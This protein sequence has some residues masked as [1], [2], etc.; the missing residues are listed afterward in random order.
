MPGTEAGSIAR[1]ALIFTLALAPAARAAAGDLDLV[2]RANGASGGSGNGSSQLPVTSKD[3]HL[4]A[5]SSSATNLTA[6]TVPAGVRQAYVRDLSA[7]TTTLASAAA[8]AN[9][10][11]V[12]MSDDGRYVVFG[13]RAT[14]LG[15]TAPGT[16]RV[17]V[18]D[19]VANTTTLVLE[20]AVRPAISADGSTIAVCSNANLAGTGATGA[21]LKVY[22]YDVQSH[23]FELVSRAPGTGAAITGD[24]PSLSDD[25]TTIAFSGQGGTA[26]IWVRDRTAQSTTLASRGSGIDG[27]QASSASIEPDISGN[28]RYVAFRSAATNL[29]DDDVDTSDDIFERDLVANTTTLVSRANGATGAGGSGDSDLPS[30]S[31]DGTR[32]FFRSRSANFSTDDNDNGDN[33]YVRD[34]V[35]G[36][37]TLVHGRVGQAPPPQGVMDGLALSG[38][39]RFAVYASSATLLPSDETGSFGDVFRRDLGAPPPPPPPPS[40]SL[41]A[42]Q[43]TLEGF[44]SHALT[45]EVTLSAADARAIAVDWRTADGTA[46]AGEDY[47]AASGQVTFAPGQTSAF[48]SVE[49]LGD[50]VRESDETF[51]IELAN[52]QNATLGRARAQVTI[53][54]DDVFAPVPSPSPTPAPGG[55]ARTSGAAPASCATKLVEGNAVLRGCFNSGGKATGIVSLNGLTVD[56]RGGVLTA[57]GD[58]VS[59]SAPVV[60]SAGDIVVHRGALKFDPARAVFFDAPSG[61]GLYGLTLGPRLMAIPSK[62]GTAKVVGQATLPFGTPLP[63]SFTTSDADGLRRDSLVVGGDATIVGT[64]TLGSLK[65][66]FDPAAAVWRGGLTV[67]VLK[68][69]SLTGTIDQRGVTSL[70]GKLIGLPNLLKVRTATVTIVP[71]PFSLKGDLAYDFGPGPLFTFD[72]TYAFTSGFS[73]TGSAKLFGIPLGKLGDIFHALLNDI[74][75]VGLQSMAA[76]AV[77]DVGHNVNAPPPPGPA[78]AGLQSILDGVGGSLLGGVGMGLDLNTGHFS[79]SGEGTFTVLGVTVGGSVTFNQ[80]GFAACGQIG[81]IQAGF[82]VH[83]NPFSLQVMGPF[84]CDVGPWKASAARA[85]GSIAVPA[86]VHVVRIHGDATLHG[87]GGQTLSTAASH[88]SPTVAVLHGDGVTYVAL[89]GAWTIEGATSAD[90]A[91]QL[92]PV[93]VT[94]RVVKNTVRYTQR[95]SAGQQVVLAEASGHELGT[96]HGTKG[97]LRFTPAPGSG[98]GDIVAIV[99]QDGLP[100]SRRVVAHYTAPKPPKPTHVTVRARGTKLTVSWK[101]ATGAVVIAK[102]PNG[103]LVARAH[104]RRAT[105]TDI[106][107]VTKATV[108]VRPN[109]GPAVSARLRR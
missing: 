43:S 18:R 84:V 103:T 6:D 91:S 25:G 39:G 41:G 22:A 81:P 26:Q 87:P 45:F 10:S 38:G 95:V 59:A 27:P 49:V 62:D 88:V 3:G 65:F 28:G 69:V 83:V 2:S 31:D 67:N 50:A 68:A 14:N 86:G 97:T 58:E 32:V 104:G 85:S 82:G 33:G 73:L 51:S 57:T 21:G 76:K 61:T 105:L 34:T 80:S 100:M 11:D 90:I 109:S 8:N 29:S 72:G 4:V 106:A 94:A 93:K 78:P 24:N 99:T 53:V 7:G 108:T 96:L 5:F 92:P 40:A 36:T 13:T 70:T 30:V 107:P 17:F 56:L 52:P 64:L 55:V 47:R 23:A 20:N 79:G 63:L 44:G 12:G 9:V 46:T 101:G 35:T 54:N 77:L 37:T 102:T 15:P 19:T 66:T 75:G 48:I 42:D 74:P 71:K 60:I 98:R 89:K 1:L 16:D